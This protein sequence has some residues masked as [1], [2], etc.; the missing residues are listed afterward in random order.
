MYT[1]LL[2]TCPVPRHGTIILN[3]QAHCLLSMDNT[4][5]RT[6]PSAPSIQIGS[7]YVVRTVAMINASSICYTIILSTKTVKLHSATRSMSSCI[8]LYRDTLPR[9]MVGRPMVVKSRREVAES[10]LRP[11]DHPEAKSH[12][13][14]IALNLELI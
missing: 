6:Q 11:Q 13:Q 14:L 4:I 8:K 1:L 2:W 9:T 10:G 5:C 3:P 12:W 7:C